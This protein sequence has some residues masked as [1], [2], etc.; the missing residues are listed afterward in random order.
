MLI[1]SYLFELAAAAKLHCHHIDLIL[2]HEV[3][4]A[5]TTAKIPF[6]DVISSIDQRIR[7]KALTSAT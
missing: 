7:C 4:L 2:G 1:D 3:N 5:I 6:E